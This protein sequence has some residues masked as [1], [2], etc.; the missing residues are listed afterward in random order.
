MVS[1][2]ARALSEAIP[3]QFL[4]LDWPNKAYVWL[5][6]LPARIELLCQLEKYVFLKALCFPVLESRHTI[7]LEQGTSLS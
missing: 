1:W 2:R 6:P 3:V 7:L 5:G 4:K